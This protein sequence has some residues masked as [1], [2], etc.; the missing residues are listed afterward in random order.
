MI[1]E[2]VS[3]DGIV[4][5]LSSIGVVVGKSSILRHRRNHPP[6]TP[7]DGVEYPPDMVVHRRAP[8]TQAAPMGDEAAQLLADIRAKIQTATVDISEDR[9]VRETLLG[10]IV[11]IQLAITAT[12]LDRYQQGEGRFPM[13]TIRGLSTVGAL[14]ER[15]VL[16]AT[17]VNETRDMLF[18]R[19]IRR[20]ENLARA[21]AKARVLRG[22]RVTG[23][24]P[25][26]HRMPREDESI[27]EAARSFED[28]L[29]FEDVEAF[30]D[31]RDCEAFVFGGMRMDGGSY[32]ARIDAAWARGIA[33]GE[34]QLQAEC[35][36]K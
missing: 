4:R 20:R 11:E 30:D 6:E 36:E 33:E 10:R 2:G 35:D 7:P 9:L 24:A 16:H 29:G 26:E 19:E 28:E 25:D 31:E 23:T 17:A 32:N 18:E 13:D 14:F 3:D 21:D 22:E 1:S 8:I 15:T 12:A 27:Y 5:S 34:A